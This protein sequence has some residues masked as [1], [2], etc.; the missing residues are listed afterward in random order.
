MDNPDVWR[1]DGG[2]T[3][4]IDRKD[5]S[6]SDLRIEVLGTVD[7]AS[8]AIGLARAGGA[9]PATKQILLEVQ[10]DL[11]WMM[12]ELADASSSAQLSTHITPDRL[13]FLAAEFTR[14]TA[15]VQLGNTFVVPG[16][17]TVSATLHLARS[18]VRRAE[19]HLTRLA[20]ATEPLNPNLLAYLN[21]LS[22]L[23]Y[24]LA[25]TEDVAAG[26]PSTEAHPSSKGPPPDAGA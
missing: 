22:A 16:D 7:E 13:V 20:L 8:S 15:E 5:V 11:C 17:T 9:R 24:A 2:L 4:I 3:D 18:I 21:R 26:T 10:R 1:G 25:R 6:K 12:S 19:R 23:L 14:L